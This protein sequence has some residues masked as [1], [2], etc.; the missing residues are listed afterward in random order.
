MLTGLLIKNIKGLVQ[1]MDDNKSRVCGN[2]MSE[3]N[4]ITDAFLYI[5]DG[6]IS[7]FGK[8]EDINTGKLLAE[9]Q[10]VEIIDASG[11]FVFP[12]FCDSHT[13]L[14]YAASREIE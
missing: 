1:T 14:V 7:D 2:E 5:N 11:R 10:M 6:L 8:M 3:L 13:H 4:F 12:S 9:S